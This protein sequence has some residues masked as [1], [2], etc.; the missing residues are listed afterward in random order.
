[1]ALHTLR[2]DVLDVTVADL[3]ARLVAVL[4]PD[5]QGRPGH[6]V[7]GCDG[8]DDYRDAE[9]YL[10]A[11]VGRVGGRIASGSFELD[12]RRYDLARNQPHA[13]LHGGPGAFDQQVWEVE[14]GSGR[15][16]VFRLTSPDGANGFP[17]AVEARAAY[18]LDGADLRLELTATADAPTPVSLLNHAYFNLSGAAS[19]EQGPLPTVEDHVLRV[20]AGR[21]LAVGEGLLPTGEVAP[22]SGTPFDLRSP[23][24]LG[25]VLD[26]EHPQLELGG[27][28]DHTLV[29]DGP[30]PGDPATADGE[31]VDGMR[32]AAELT[33]PASGRQ[34]RLFT[35]R[36]ALQVYA[37]GLLT[38]DLRLRGALTAVPRGGLCLEPQGF[39]DAVNHP[40]FP[41]V[42]LRPGETFRS[43]SLLRFTAA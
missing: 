41:S 14:P 21:Y 38:R 30:E 40:G 9:G 16:V 12:G 4:A 36:P 22:V 31:V 2:S 15:R 27:G 6:V 32:L 17:G 8:E 13:T 42:V 7:L 19:A 25:D 20:P 37:G 43:R 10:G 23:V 26:V 35:D 11:T 33:H 24:R 18:A 1:M 5:R 29:L 34:L 28:L 3:G 39:P